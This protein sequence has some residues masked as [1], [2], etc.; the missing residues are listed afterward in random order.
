MGLV[1][2]QVASKAPSQPVSAV[3]RPAATGRLRACGSLP[4]GAVSSS[5]TSS[6]SCSSSAARCAASAGP[7]IRQRPAER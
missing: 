6:A 1:E 5:D 2:V 3:T 4:P 7:T